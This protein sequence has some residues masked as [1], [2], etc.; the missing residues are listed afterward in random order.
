MDDGSDGGHDDPAPPAPDMGA[1]AGGEGSRVEA[2]VLSPRAI[3][4][5]EINEEKT[6][7]PKGIFSFNQFHVFFLNS[8]LGPNG[9]GEKI[10]KYS[11]YLD[12]KDI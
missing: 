2:E 11:K 10:H 9:E 12:P 8:F 1:G 3:P 5:T 7:S 6:P 4:T